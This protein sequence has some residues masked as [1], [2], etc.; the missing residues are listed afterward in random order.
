MEDSGKSNMACRDGFLL[1][2]CHQ[3]SSGNSFGILTSF[4]ANPVQSSRASTACNNAKEAGSE[5]RLSLV[6][7]TYSGTRQLWW[8]APRAHK[9][10]FGK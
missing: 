5:P 7:A 4:R 6:N 10:L 2:C 8:R 1:F 3:R 9:Q